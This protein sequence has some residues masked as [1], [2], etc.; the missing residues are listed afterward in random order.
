MAYLSLLK[1]LHDQAR[2][3][4]ESAALAELLR[5]PAVL[6]VFL[7]AIRCDWPL[8]QGRADTR[9]ET[10]MPNGRRADLD[11]TWSVAGMGYRLLVENKPYASL[12]KG[13]PKGYIRELERE[14]R[15]SGVAFLFGYQ[16]AVREWRRR[17]VRHASP[18]TPRRKTARKWAL[19]Q[20]ALAERSAPIAVYR[21]SLARLALRLKR[22][23]PDLPP[24]LSEIHDWYV[25]RHVDY[26]SKVGERLRRRFDQLTEGSPR[27]QA[28]RSD[29][30]TVDREY[31]FHGAELHDEKHKGKRFTLWLGV[32]PDVARLLG[33]SDDAV[34]L[35]A[36]GWPSPDR[37]EDLKRLADEFGASWSEFPVVSPGLGRAMVVESSSRV[38][39]LIDRL[40]E[41]DPT[42]WSAPT[43]S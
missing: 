38:D 25:E 32:E 21:S 15:V 19:V 18:G 7:R 17:L 13:Q 37:A 20:R 31:G 16:D 8:P 4:V 29:G 41:L 43:A 26:E 24:Q 34:L 14:T 1:L 22:G 42:G 30:L 35:Q 3:Q 2:E 9:V 6:G 40:E 27:F 11:I 28:A 12:T 10:Q 23:K 5:E 33:Q 39:E 36:V